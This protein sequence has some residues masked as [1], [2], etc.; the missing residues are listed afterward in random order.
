MRSGDLRNYDGKF[1]RQNLAND[2]QGVE[3]SG[4][5]ALLTSNIVHE[6]LAT[7]LVWAANM[8]KV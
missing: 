2:I 7:V 4:G 3:V 8:S 1:D 6:I 5:K